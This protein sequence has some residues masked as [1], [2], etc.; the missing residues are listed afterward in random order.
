MLRALRSIAASL[1]APRMNVPE[2]VLTYVE[3][4]MLSHAQAAGEMES[5]LA[6]MAFVAAVRAE[7][8]KAALAGETGERHVALAEIYLS[9]TARLEA[10]RSPSERLAILESAAALH[11]VSDLS[12]R[13]R[14]LQIKTGLS[15]IWL[16]SRHSSL[17]RLVGKHEHG[18][19]YALARCTLRDSAVVGSAGEGGEVRLWNLDRGVCVATMRH[20]LRSTATCV[21]AV[22][23]GGE[24]FL[25]SGHDDGSLLCWDGLS[26]RLLNQR[27]TAWKRPFLALHAVVWGGSH[28]LLGMTGSGAVHRWNVKRPFGLARR[29]TDRHRVAALSFA[30]HAADSAS[31]YAIGCWDGSIRR[32]SLRTGRRVRRPTRAHEGGV[33]ALAYG[34]CQGRPALISGGADGVIRAWDV[35]TGEPVCEPLAGHVGW[36]TALA[37]E[38]G[39]VRL[40]LS[41][42]GDCTLRSWDLDRAAS[43]G[44][45]RARHRGWVHAIQ[46]VSVRAQRR[47]LTATGDFSLCSWDLGNPLTRRQPELGHTRHVSGLA[48]G[49]VDGRRVVASG[50]HDGGMGVWDRDTGDPLFLPVKAHMGWV[51]VSL[52]TLAGKGVVA[53]G[54]SGGFVRLWDAATGVPLSENLDLGGKAGSSENRRPVTSLLLG[55]EAGRPTLFAAHG[56]GGRLVRLQGIPGAAEVVQ[57]GP[58]IWP[59]RRMATL[60]LPRAPCL[61]L[62]GCGGQIHMLDLDRGEL[63]T[64][65]ATELGD[66]L[67]YCSLATSV[68]GADIRLFVGGSEGQIEILDASTGRAESCI[69]EAHLGRVTALAAL[70]GM[71]GQILL[72]GDEDGDIKAWNPVT[73]ECLG[74]FPQ[75]APIIALVADEGGL[76]AVSYGVGFGMLEVRL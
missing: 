3:T 62:L 28:T 44:V 61:A 37:Q 40:T 55:E 4:H 69:R 19:P 11:A 6:D 46:P 51:V 70:E 26:G 72:S 56:L 39:D 30:V 73:R 48:V 60:S 76:V 66:G 22:E 14:A 57:S 15:P 47:V 49:Q 75:A 54:S 33:T 10:A 74:V 17:H 12:S 18:V 25:F 34:A 23:A 7:T 8:M 20:P 21:A 45:R 32:Y 67:V 2:S 13:I 9:A 24:V 31:E 71:T 64:P 59:V 36:V 41:A 29:K 53:T 50:S 5:A 58:R 38:Q 68:P 52:G 1:L 16:H 27:W 65:F 42:G 43:L 63:V 35:A